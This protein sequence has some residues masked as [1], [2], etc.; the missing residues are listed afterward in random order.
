MPERVIAASD[1]GSGDIFLSEIDLDSRV[2][3]IRRGDDL[4][5]KAMDGGVASVVIEG[6][7]TLGVAPSL[8]FSGGAVLP[9]E[10]VSSFLQT[11]TSA[12]LALGYLRD[13]LSDDSSGT[14]GV[15]AGAE[16]T[17]QVTRAGLVI[18]LQVGDS[19]HLDD[20]ISTGSDSEVFL[21]FIDDMEFRLGSEGRLAINSFVYDEVNSS[22]TQVL[23]IISGAFSYASGLIERSDP[24]SV[25]LLTP[26]GTIGIR[27]TKILGDVDP[28]SAGLSVTVL[29]GS[30]ALLQDE[31]EVATISKA[32]ETLKVTNYGNGEQGISITRDTVSDVFARY[33]FLDG[34]VVELE[35]VWGASEDI[36]GAEASSLEAIALET[37]ASSSSASIV[38]SSVV[39]LPATITEVAIDVAT[40]ATTSEESVITAANAFY[41]SGSGDDDLASLTST[42]TGSSGDDIL[43]GSAGNDR[44]SGFAGNDRFYGFAGDD[45]LIGGV[46]VDEYYFYVGDGN[47]VIMDIGDTEITFVSS[48]RGEYETDDFSYDIF[49][50]VGNS[51][52][53]DLNVG[54]V[55]QSVTISDYY[56]EPHYGVFSLNYVEG[57]SDGGVPNRIVIP[58]LITGDARNNVLEA[59]AG[60]ANYVLNG[61]GGKDT[62]SYA[63][64][65]SEVTANLADSSQ[66]AGAADGDIFISIE[67]LVGASGHGNILTGDDK[68]NDL[69]GGREGD[70]LKGAAGRDRLFGESGSDNL[71][72]DDGIDTLEGGVGGDNLY[73]GAG[74][75]I[76]SF[77]P[78]DGTDIITDAD[79]GR[80]FFR[81]SSSVSYADSD[82]A[83][84][85][86]SRLGDS[87]QLQFTV[88][89]E[90]QQVTIADY[91]SNSGTFTISYNVAAGGAYKEA[92]IPNIILGRAIGETL[93]G[94][95][96]VDVIR[97]KAGADVLEGGLG[98][99]I[100]DGGLGEDTASYA[101]A[102]SQVTASLADSSQNRGA[103]AAGDS[104]TSIENLRGA[105]GVVN[106]LTGD[107]GNNKLYGGDLIDE[108]SGNAG[109]DV[110]EGGGGIDEYLFFAGG[111]RDTIRGDLDGGKLYFRDAR[112]IEDFSFSRAVNGDVIITVETAGSTDRVVID[113]A[114][115]APDRFSLHYGASDTALGSFWV[116]T[117]TANTID[118]Y[119]VG[120]SIFAGAE[121][122]DIFESYTGE[123]ALLGGAGD[124]DYIVFGTWGP[125]TIVDK[126]GNNDVYLVSKTGHNPFKV[127]ELSRIDNDLYIKA[128]LRGTS[129]YHEVTIK[130]YYD[131]D[132]PS[133]TFTIYYNTN[134][135]DTFMTAAIPS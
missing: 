135:G 35:E 43:E 36:A 48:A 80:L 59:G 6:Y 1:I 78:V 63:L 107:G 53:I 5:I 95:A 9:P 58:N 81:S 54:G 40:T 110:L 28:A 27:G 23:S 4:V 12:K 118:T 46:G 77:S 100:L 44:L 71:Y 34:S 109:N 21:R 51:L 8:L 86:F 20:I 117:R 89:G 64:A 26:Y 74:A 104:Y 24:N 68:A 88:S 132:T 18:T 131:D 99:D 42:T 31:R 93:T 130:G 32:F 52:R 15:V 25:E 7:F 128:P 76:Y 65:T 10:L 82:F 41:F 127:P 61:K 11:D 75:D 119:M 91:Y 2:E 97:A 111:G 70:T 60:T 103:D 133:D 83:S 123:V 121:G 37:L 69:R 106:I 30:V 90:V 29:E 22:G 85:S 116:G 101:G 92:S 105:A 114:S 73:G 19:I 16:G 134:I 13:K 79:G 38:A 45:I 3:F 108:L 98:G 87:L 94:T 112:G 67:N 62:A 124:D 17:V 120:G 49:T 66:N 84:T 122:N 56:S 96:G 125:K 72:G 102:S 33:D 47:D 14:I 50:R 55:K 39:S 57:S 113:S 126:E 129:F 115:Y